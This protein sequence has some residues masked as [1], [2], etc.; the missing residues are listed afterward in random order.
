MLLVPRPPDSAELMPVRAGDAA[1]T[2]CL[3]VLPSEGPSSRH[4]AESALAALH[5]LLADP[6]A[7]APRAATWRQQLLLCSSAAAL[8]GLTAEYAPV[9]HEQQL[10]RAQ[11]GH[12]GAGSGLLAGPAW[13][14]GSSDTGA[15]LARAPPGRL[16]E[17]LQG[18]RSSSGFLRPSSHGSASG[19]PSPLPPLAP[20]P[21]SSR[22]CCAPPGAGRAGGQGRSRAQAAEHSSMVLHSTGSVLCL[23][24]SPLT[25]AASA[26]MSAPDA[27]A[28]TPPPV[29][30][31]PPINDPA[32][33]GYCCASLA[34]GLAA[35]MAEAV[36]QV[37]VGC[38]ERGRLLAQLWNSYT[39]VCVACV[40]VYACVCGRR[41]GGG[42]AALLRAA[43]SPVQQ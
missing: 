20:P 15:G 25:K 7:A 31:P 12:A 37:E 2:P 32:W 22:L 33:D 30:P 21:A 39:G 42:A 16:D 14:A 3:L 1:G 40:C 38:A 41:G 4:E 18:V 6:A 9:Q 28:P 43:S 11:P 27:A 5:Q 35:C 36:R 17:A 10:R 8:L 13:L 23:D 19:S 26:A 24:S 29:L 34:A